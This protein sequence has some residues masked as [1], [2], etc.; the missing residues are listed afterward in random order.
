K[1]IQFADVAGV[2]NDEHL[3]LSEGWLTGF[4]TWFN[5]KQFKRHGEAASS[6]PEVVARER[7]RIDDLIQDLIDNSGYELRDLYNMDETGLFYAYVLFD[8]KLSGQILIV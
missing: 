5:L 6:T 3:G 2:P 4:K 7:Q 1:W 8:H